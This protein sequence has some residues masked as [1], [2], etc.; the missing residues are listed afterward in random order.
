M[1]AIV[2]QES[3]S[4]SILA[5]RGHL[6]RVLPDTRRR[7]RCC[8]PC[9]TIHSVGTVWQDQPVPS[10]PF[11]LT[12][13]ERHTSDAHLRALPTPCLSGCGSPAPQS[14]STRPASHVGRHRDA[15]VVWVVTYP[16]TFKPIPD[17]LA[18]IL[19]RNARE[20][21]A[22]HTGTAISS[23]PSA[24]SGSTIPSLVRFP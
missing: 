9:A 21:H 7:R 11:S 12:V 5:D 19:L 15:G 10:L 17:G 6:H 22:R 24:F 13:L 2:H 14:L 4:T 23:P 20:R 16:L 18:S 1:K 3:T 8:C